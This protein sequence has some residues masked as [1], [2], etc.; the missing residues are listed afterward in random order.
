MCFDLILKDEK[1]F[2]KYVSKNVS[3]SKHFIVV[4][5]WFSYTHFLVQTRKHRSNNQFK[6]YESWIIITFRSNPIVF[7]K[8]K[9]AEK[10]CENL[11][12]LVKIFMQSWFRSFGIG[13]WILWVSKSRWKLGL[14]LG[15]FCTIQCSQTF[16][17]CSKQNWF[18]TRRLGHLH[19][20]IVIEKFD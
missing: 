11:L 5:S 13:C 14:T 1:T 17:R 10:T 7:D 20:P 18:V 16:T 15:C 12:D 9:E 19:N 6:N 2:I 4:I 8:K 3:Q